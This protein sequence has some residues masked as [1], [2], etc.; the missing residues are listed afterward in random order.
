MALQGKITANRGYRS[1]GTQ[2]KVIMAKNI[3]ISG[4]T[5]TLAALTDV[6]TS[7]RTDGSLIQW[8]S[9]AGVFKVK[10]EIQDT[11]SNLKLIGGTF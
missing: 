1:A 10:P 7:A 11:N 6:D 9:T 5:T 4:E 2:K 8:D 3:S